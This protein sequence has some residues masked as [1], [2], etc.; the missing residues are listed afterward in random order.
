MLEPA[1]LARGY[2]VRV[3]D[4]HIDAIPRM[5][6]SERRVTENDEL[7]TTQPR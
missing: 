3:D 1:K 6:E 7:S 5:L 4:P 2:L